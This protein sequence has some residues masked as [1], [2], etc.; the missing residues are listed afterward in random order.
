MSTVDQ[1]NPRLTTSTVEDK[2][3]KNALRPILIPTK[4]TKKKFI[5]IGKSVS[6]KRDYKHRDL[7]FYTFDIL[8][9]S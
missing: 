7:S 6:E 4:Y 8:I 5:K 9:Y 1:K 2:R 3:V